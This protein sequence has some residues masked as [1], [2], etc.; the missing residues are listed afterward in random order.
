MMTIYELAPMFLDAT[1]AGMELT[2]LDDTS[3]LPACFDGGSTGQPRAT[4]TTTDGGAFQVLE[5]ERKHLS[6]HRQKMKTNIG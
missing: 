1:N 3:S 2:V 5:G 4:D 6:G